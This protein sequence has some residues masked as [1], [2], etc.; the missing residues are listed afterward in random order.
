M[1]ENFQHSLNWAIAVA[2]VL[3]TLSVALTEISLRLQ[4]ANGAL[5]APVALVRDLILPALSAL[6]L[7]ICIVGSTASS[8]EVRVVKTIFWL[9]V[10]H[11]A[12]SFV[13]AI[14]FVNAREGSWEAKMPRL[15]IDIARGLIV[16]FC[17]AVVLSRVW[18]QNLGQLVA[19]LGVGSLV[20]GLALQEPVGNLFSGIMV[21]M[22]RPIGAGDWVKVGDSVGA[23]IESTWRSVHLRTRDGD[24]VVIPNS[25]LA[26]G[27]FVN[28]SRPTPSHS[29]SVTMHFS[30]ENAPNKVKLMLL[31]SAL[32]TQGVL[33]DPGPKVRLDD[34]EDSCIAYEV[35]L[36]IVDFARLKDIADEFRTLVWYASQREGLTMPYPTER[37]IVVSESSPESS[38]HAGWRE[39][40]YAEALNAFPHLGLSG[41]D[42]PNAISGS[43]VKHYARGEHVVREGQRLSGLHLVV[44]GRVKLT[45]RHPDGYEVEIARI[46]RGE[47]FGERSLLSSAPSE[48]T[49]TALED[50]ELL[51][52]DSDAV[53]ALIEK[54]PQLWQRIGDVMEA[55]RRALGTARRIVRNS[56]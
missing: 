30:C 45:A 10:T 34:F 38:Q 53:H 55:R 5:A 35:K 33:A 40:L 49:V 25:I 16:L 15:F 50:L 37:R 26:K 1:D 2:I 4:R 36:P 54:T 8:I 17:L 27:S 56:S 6:V 28:Y 43:A 46:E 21:M 18:G 23:V 44:R 7:L 9:F 32:C 39:P 11:T 48:A 22:E 24:L 20:L 3:P 52:L 51:V 31:E 12:L 29:E 14:M 47:F 41:A 13:S 19:A 42:G